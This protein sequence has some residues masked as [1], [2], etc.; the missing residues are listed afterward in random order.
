MKSVGAYEAKVHLSEL[1][2]EVENGETVEI[3]RNGRPVAKLVSIDESEQ[4]RNAHKIEKA[5][6]E[7]LAYRKEH[8]ITLGGLS[9]R[10][11]VEEGRM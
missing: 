2:R 9:I 5:I 10:E 4:K 8:N 7:W 1:L 11:L 6:D 3:T